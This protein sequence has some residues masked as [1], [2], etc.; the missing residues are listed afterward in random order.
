MHAKGL[1]IDEIVKKSVLGYNYLIENNGENLSGGERMRIIIARSIIR[2]FNIY[3]YDETFSGLDVT[4]ERDILNY[5]FKLYPDKTFII[6]SHRDSNCDLYDKI[7]KFGEEN[8]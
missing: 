5:L 1:F 2:A 3:I 4:L 7:I 8:A 6:V